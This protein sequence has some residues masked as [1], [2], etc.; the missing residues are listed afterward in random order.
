MWGYC[1]ESTRKKESITP[2]DLIS[3]FIYIR[4]QKDII[5]LISTKNI[6]TSK[7]ALIKE[8]ISSSDTLCGFYEKVGDIGRSIFSKRSSYLDLDMNEDISNLFFN[9]GRIFLSNLVGNFAIQS[10]SKELKDSLFINNYSISEEL[11]STLN[12]LSSEFGE[13]CYSIYNTI[14]KD[15][16]G[17]NIDTSIDCVLNLTPY[18]DDDIRNMNNATILPIM[19]TALFYSIL[20]YIMKCFS[21]V[22][23]KEV[24]GYGKEDVDKLNVSVNSI[25]K[26]IIEGSTEGTDKVYNLSLMCYLY[27]KITSYIEV[28]IGKEFDSRFSK[29]FKELG[30]GFEKTFKASKESDKRLGINELIISFVEDYL[31]NP[32][33]NIYIGDHI[34]DLRDFYTR[35]IIDNNTKYTPPLIYITDKEFDYD[36]FIRNS[37]SCINITEY[38]K[39]IKSAIKANNIV[40]TNKCSKKEFIDAWYRLRYLEKAISLSLAKWS[41][42]KSVFKIVGMDDLFVEM[43]SPNGSI[44]KDYKNINDVQYSVAYAKAIDIILKLNARYCEAIEYNYSIVAGGTFDLDYYKKLSKVSFGHFFHENVISAARESQLYKQPYFISLGNYS[45]KEIKFEALK[46]SYI[47]TK[48]ISKLEVLDTQ[49][50][51]NPTLRSPYEIIN[52]GCFNTTIIS[53]EDS[54]IVNELYDIIR[55]LNIQEYMYLIK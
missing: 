15:F 51:N 18:F 34:Y 37:S 50:N 8:G 36:Y 42:T 5:D 54:S 26:E 1:M 13:Q 28:S 47:D 16:A 24:M 27:T 12:G 4:Y 7:Y 14:K 32:V 30:N 41:D 33:S 3:L 53:E 6:T 35:Q 17:E 55:G 48:K 22:R 43:R 46:G 23:F 44:V 39:C 29:I 49:Y 19:N 10:N 2:L 20:G 38:D 11:V 9:S 21:S 25:I 45:E 52:S 31:I 40:S